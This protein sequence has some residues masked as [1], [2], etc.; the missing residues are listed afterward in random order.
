MTKVL[1]CSGFAALCLAPA[2]AALADEAALSALSQGGHA[3]IMR[4][5]KTSGRSKALVLDPNGNCANEENLSDEGRAQA[6][7]LKSLLDTVGAEFDTVLTSP[8]C[9]ARETARLAF[10]V[11]VVDVAL[12]PLETG[13]QEEVRLRTEKIN[14]LLA[15]QAAKG[16]IALITHRSNVQLETME[17]VEEGEVIIAK[18]RPNGMLD[19]IAKFKP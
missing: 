1:A 10:G 13:T 12:A 15:S 5:A 2:P 3:V 19:V 9:R 11:E 17:L 7:R 8:F 4:H 6:Q 14:G 16:N 18:I